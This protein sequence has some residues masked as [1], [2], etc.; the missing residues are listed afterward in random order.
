MNDS[1][2]L[3]FRLG[4]DIPDELLEL[5]LSHPSS[6]GE[7]LERTLKSNQRLEFLGDSLVGAIVAEYSYRTFPESPEGELTK[8]KIAAVRREALASAARRLGLGQ[9]LQF[10][11]GEDSAGGR[12]RDSNLS[13]AFEALVGALFLAQGWDVTRDFVL[14]ILEPELRR[15]SHTLT[16]AKNRLQELSQAIGLGTPSYKTTQVAPPRHYFASDVILK[17]EKRGRGQG[18]SKKA[19]EEAAAQIALDALLTERTIEPSAASEDGDS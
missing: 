4:L 2:S 18:N 19:A 12:E 3:N 9:V 6:V 17:G 16:S 1:S 14:Q 15:D 10:G 7:G 8:R 11:R 13:D 5:A